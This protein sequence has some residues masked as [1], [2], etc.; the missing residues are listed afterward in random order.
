M[1]EFSKTRAGMRFLNVDLPGIAKQLERIAE[2]LE[3]KNQI[4]EKRLLLEHKKYLREGR[5]LRENDI[6]TDSTNT[7]FR[8]LP[9]DEK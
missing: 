9:Q 1:D 8:D 6:D 4:E 3:K 2:G 5:L 7:D